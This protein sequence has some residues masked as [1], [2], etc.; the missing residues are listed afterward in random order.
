MTR[1]IADLTPRE[2][3]VVIHRC[4]PME[5]S[6]QETARVMGITEHTVKNHGTAIIRKLGVI[7]FH[8]VCRVYGEQTAWQRMTAMRA[9][10][11]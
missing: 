8:G 5:L 11:V 3:A 7:S 2:R 9:E 1:W 4:G 6:Q 10:M